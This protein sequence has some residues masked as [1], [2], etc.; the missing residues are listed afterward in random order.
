MTPNQK[1]NMLSMSHCK[2]QE[3]EGGITIYIKK[4]DPSLKVMV[5]GDVCDGMFCNMQC[6]E[7]KL[8]PCG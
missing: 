3:D 2:K 1:T 5:D 8:I 6:A 7:C 4:N